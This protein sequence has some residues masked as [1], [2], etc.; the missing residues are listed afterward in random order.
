VD[1]API[2]RYFGT[3]SNTIDAAFEGKEADRGPITA[4]M[5]NII[6]GGSLYVNRT[7]NARKANKTY[8]HLIDLMESAPIPRLTPDEE[9]VFQESYERWLAH[10]EALL[11]GDDEDGTGSTGGGVAY[12]GPATAFNDD[13]GEQPAVGSIKDRILD[14]LTGGPLPLKEIRRHMPDVAPGS[15]NN[16]MTD[17]REAGAVQPAGARGVYQLTN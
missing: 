2:P 9:R 10:A 6:N 8:P 16:A 5:A 14:L 7:W 15:V 4:G 11:T 3:G 1:L 12:S 13:E 17:L